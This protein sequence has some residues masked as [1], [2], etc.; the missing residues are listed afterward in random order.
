MEPGPGPIVI[1][2]GRQT[3]FSCSV[4]PESIVLGWVVL[5]PS[6]QEGREQFTER[7][8]SQKHTLLELGISERMI[9]SSSSELQVNAS[10]ENINL[11]YVICEGRPIS[12]Y[13]PIRSRQVNVTIYGN[14]HQFFLV[15][16]VLCLCLSFN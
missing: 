14:I 10:S 13:T 15:M 16:Y 2:V 8:S 4:N 7:M 11:T 1:P 5:I 12:T 6:L 3:T 9:S